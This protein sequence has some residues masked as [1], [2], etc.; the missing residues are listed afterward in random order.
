M[1]E[2][3]IYPFKLEDLDK[4]SIKMNDVFFR[5]SVEMIEVGFNR[6]MNNITLFRLLEGD[7][8][9]YLNLHDD[10]WEST[11]IDAIQHF[12]YIEDYEMCTKTKEILDILIA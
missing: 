1:S 8:E 9:L 10:M 12:E 6:D 7:T 4:Y 3:P 11:L 5:R 2:I